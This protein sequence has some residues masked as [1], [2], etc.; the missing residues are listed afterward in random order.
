MD[1]RKIKENEPQAKARG[2]FYTKAGERYMHS[3]TRSMVVREAMEMH[4]HD[5]GWRVKN[6]RKVLGIKR[7]E[8]ALEC[9]I[10]KKW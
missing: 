9:G 2:F 3:H 4:T 6:V 7:G 1:E 8:M 10:S 5:A